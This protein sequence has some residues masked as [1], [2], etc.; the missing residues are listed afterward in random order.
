MILKF[1]EQNIE[2]L[3]NE[4]LVILLVDVD[5]NISAQQMA[6]ISKVSSR[7]LEKYIDKLKRLEL[8]KRI[9]A[10]KTGQWQIC[11]PTTNTNN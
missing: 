7:S 3:D 1:T 9:G 2:I 5:P 8:L 11:T 4:L 10:N 6:H